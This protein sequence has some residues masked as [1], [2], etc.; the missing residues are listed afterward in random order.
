MF[1]I[2]GPLA[3]PAA[4]DYI[5]LGVYDEKLMEPMAKVLINL[6]IK[7]AMLVH[8]NDGLDEI[9]VS[10][11]TT[12]CEIKDAKIIKYEINPKD[13][14]VRISNKSEVVGGTA[15]ENA[16]ITLDILSGKQGATRDIV[17]M[18]AGCAIYVAKKA[19]SIA[20]GIEMARQSIDSGNALKKLEELKA[21][22]N[23]L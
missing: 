1:N 9:T 20:E 22:T 12:I 17:L 6:G 15:V 14:G 16:K 8:G 7:G 19:N 3:N 21:F 11:S 13:F 23:S 2:L 4:T 10:D 5:V 18:N